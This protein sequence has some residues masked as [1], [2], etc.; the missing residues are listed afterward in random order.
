MKRPKMVIFLSMYVCLL[1]CFALQ[2]AITLAY[3]TTG[4]SGLVAIPLAILG[5]VI[6]QQIW[7]NMGNRGCLKLLASAV[8]CSALTT[9]P[10][11]LGFVYLESAGG[12]PSITTGGMP[13]NFAGAILIGTGIFTVVMG[14]KIV[15]MATWRITSPHAAAIWQKFKR[16]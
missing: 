15:T 5:A 9:T 13:S 16:Y 7:S 12:S 1:S 6:T 2:H 3:K 8:I 10:V 4:L 14:V 11:F